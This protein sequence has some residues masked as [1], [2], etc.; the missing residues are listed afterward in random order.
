MN[1]SVKEKPTVILGIE[2]SC[3][4]TSAAVIIDG[5]LYSNITAGQEVHKKY[6]GVVPE[7]ASRAHQANIVPVVDLA[8]K[9]AGVN[10]KNVSAVAFTQGPG[11]LGSL[12]VGASFAKGFAL[13]QSVPLLAENHLQGHIAALFLRE[14]GDAAPLPEY[15]FLTM[16]VSGGHTQI[17]KVTDFFEQ[18]VIGETIDDAAGEAFDKCAKIMGMGYPGGP[19]IDRR[20]KNGNSEAFRFAKPRIPA[21][22]YSF[23]GLK[24]SFLYSVRDRAAENPNFVSENADDLCASIQ[25]TIIDI[26]M[27]KFSKA[28]EQSGINEIAVAGGVSANSALRNAFRDLAADKKL[29]LH[30]PAFKY[31]TDNAAMIAISG[32]HHFLKGEFSPHDVSAQARLKLK[33]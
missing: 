26:L 2:S 23:S 1:K 24:T 8:L 30:I 6:G 33:P 29:R 20:A 9:E 11:L 14:P 3:D 19:V 5:V 21:L 32:Y 22:D 27:D 25:K 4:D 28:I 17:I 10:K 16:L 12:L 13:A 31:T 15:P 7:L 18:E